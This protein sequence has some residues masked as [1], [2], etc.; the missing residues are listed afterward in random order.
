MLPGFDNSTFIAVEWDG[1]T[2]SIFLVDL[3]ARGVRIEGAGGYFR[4]GG[5]GAH[6][7]SILWSFSSALI[8]SHSLPA[9]CE[10]FKA[11]LN[12]VP[13]TVVLRALVATKSADVA[14]A[15][16]STS[17]ILSEQFT[18]PNCSTCA[19]TSFIEPVPVLSYS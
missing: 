9:S 2:V 17:R 15:Y 13:P 10:R 6:R 12:L 19:V 4:R 7:C 14:V 11:A 16:A 5:S 8:A 1:K 3:I 18:G